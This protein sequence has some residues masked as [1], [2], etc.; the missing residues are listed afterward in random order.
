MKKKRVSS[1]LAAA[2][3]FV[4]LAWPIPASAA[5]LYFT[6]INDS[7]APLSSDTMPFWSGGTLYVPYTVFDANQNGINVSL[8]L[9][10][11]YNRG[12]GTITLF[13]LRQMLVFDLNKGTCWDDM[14]GTTYSSR[15]ILRNGKPFLSLNMVCSFFG[16]EYSYS[17][18]PYIAQGYLVR[19]KN[20][21]AVNDDAGFIDAARNVINNRFRDYTQSLS[22]ADTTNPARPGTG[23]GTTPGSGN[24]SGTTKPSASAPLE[25]DD[26]K[27]ATYLAFRCESAEGLT[28]ILSALDSGGER[29]VF[30]LTPQLLE[31]EG[32]LVRRALGTGH[33]VGILT[34]G[35]EE[36][37]RQLDRGTRALEAAA[38]TRTTLAY[39]PDSHRAALE[40]EGWV[41]WQETT[42]LQPDGSTN[43]STYASNAVRR[44]GN[45]DSTV[46]LTLEGGENTVDVLPALLRDLSR[47]NYIVSIPLETRL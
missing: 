28:D 40:E 45:R 38:H 1:I 36:V 42:L 31:D 30:F 6:A 3:L 7:V 35:G 16:L 4:G 41:C 14:T 18:L 43:S 46:Y 24:N 47:D 13:N 39:A 22:S 33:S 17:Q 12:S 25:P 44:L 2:V 26:T 34:G 19:I 9:Y 15:A 8:G 37:E 21:G 27:T 29:A 32:D 10:T 23:G 20:A 5:N 11:S